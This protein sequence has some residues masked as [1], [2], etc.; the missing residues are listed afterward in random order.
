MGCMCALAVTCHLHFWLNDHGL[1]CATGCNKFLIMLVPWLMVDLNDDQEHF[2]LLHCGQQF[3]GSTGTCHMFYFCRWDQKDPKEVSWLFTDPY[4]LKTQV[5]QDWGR[6]LCSIWRQ[7]WQLISTISHDMHR[8]WLV[9]KLQMPIVWQLAHSKLCSHSA[10][11]HL[12][13]DFNYD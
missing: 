8:R 12:D 9:R 1:L 2:Q 5:S 13:S 10:E 4:Q 7:G 11:H 3:D 6:S